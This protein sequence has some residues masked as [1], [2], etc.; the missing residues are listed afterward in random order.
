MFA[1]TGSHGDNDFLE[2]YTTPIKGEPT[3]VVVRVSFNPAGK[4]QHIVVNH[5]PRS[6]LLL[7]SRLMGEKFAHTAIGEHFITSEPESGRPTTAGA[8]STATSEFGAVP[9]K[10]R[11][12][13]SLRARSVRRSSQCGVFRNASTS[14]ANAVWCWNKNPRA[15]SG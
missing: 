8:A 15:A 1:F 11:T 9:L 13:R 6:S 12:E 10:R 7:F 14:C 4:A 2:E 5:R 3:G